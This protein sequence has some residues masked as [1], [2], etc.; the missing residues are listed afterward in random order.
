MKQIGHDLI[1]INGID[2]VRK[3]SLKVLDGLSLDDIHILIHRTNVEIRGKVCFYCGE[4][5][6]GEQ[7]KKLT[8][9]HGINK[10]LK[11]KYNVF[12]PICYN[13]HLKIN[14]SIKRKK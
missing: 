6:G 2:Y 5:F 8:K 14:K 12:I 4:L 1:T 11:S 9:H 7:N 13:C 3:G 10:K